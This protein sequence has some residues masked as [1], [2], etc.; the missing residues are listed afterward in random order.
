MPSDQTSV[1]YPWVAIT[2]SFLSSGVGH[3]YCGRIVRGLCLYSA[4]F[5]LPLLCLLAVFAEPSTG[6]L[7][8]LILAPA[9]ATLAI[10]LY[11]PCDAYAIARRSDPGYQLKEYNRAGLYGLLI[12]MQLAYPVALTL[13]TRAYVYQA[14]RIPGRSMSPSFLAGDR[15]LVNKRPFG[16]DS[17]KRGDVI[18]FRTSLAEGGQVWIKRVIG[19]GGDRIVIR[20]RE[21]EINGQTLEHER[22]STDSQDW[23]R[24]Q[25]TDEVCFESNAGNR[26]PVLFAKEGPEEPGMDQIDVTV[27]DQSV[28]VMGDNRDRSK[29]SRSIGSI[30]VSNVIGHVEYIFYPAESWSRF[31]A[32]RNEQLSR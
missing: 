1:R 6:V 23:I 20:G 7:L 9:A 21:I 18:V 3:I 26:Y 22:V 16:G 4:R 28:F 8:G 15:F 25:A 5:F 24:E 29:D 13:A 30:P 31:G 10:F 14:F 11:A 17:P 12:A 2:L 19:I 32:P 27:P